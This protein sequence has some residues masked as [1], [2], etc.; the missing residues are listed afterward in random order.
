[1]QLPMSWFYLGEQYTSPDNFY[2]VSVPLHSIAADG[3]YSV[4]AVDTFG[5]GWKGFSATTDGHITILQNSDNKTKANS[6]Q[7][8]HSW[9]MQDA[10][11]QTTAGLGR[12]A[13]QQM[14]HRICNADASQGYVVGTFKAFSNVCPTTEKLTASFGSVT[15]ECI[16]NEKKGPT[17]RECRDKC[18]VLGDDCTHY[19]WF[20]NAGPH[21]QA[22]WGYFDDGVA[23]VDKAYTK[24]MSFKLESTATWLQ[25]QAQCTAAGLQLCSHRDIC[26]NGELNAP[27]EGI[28]SKDT[29]VPTSDSKNTWVSVGNRNILQRL[30]RTHTKSTGA[31]PNW[32]DDDRSLEFRSKV[33]CCGQSSVGTC[34]T[35]KFD[36]DE[37]MNKGFGNDD[38]TS[39]ASDGTTAANTA[40]GT[41]IATAASSVSKSRPADNVKQ[42][43]DCPTRDFRTFARASNAGELREFNVPVVI[44]KHRNGVNRDY[45]V[46]QHKIE[47]FGEEFEI[48]IDPKDCPPGYYCPQT[49]PK[50]LQNKDEQV[51]LTD[52]YDENKPNN[53]GVMKVSCANFPYNGPENAAELADATTRPQWFNERLHGT[54]YGSTSNYFCPGVSFFVFLVSHFLLF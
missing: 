8:E 25:A 3:L 16:E 39:V 5:D 1:M 40:D 9:I 11:R 29:W 52:Y 26:P 51:T 4:R 19:A 47:A 6:Y 50:M 37:L 38:S 7:V 53:P 30:C 20:I 46:Y 22:S 34:L 27:F 10:H 42:V 44:F 28:D 13:G 15:P 45:R 41:P 14:A 12:V 36:I 24:V 2:D 17:H 49:V 43:Q 23:T 33:F 32:S 48:R 35:W 31:K 54:D 21:R 18:R